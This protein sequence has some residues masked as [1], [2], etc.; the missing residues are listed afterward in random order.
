M[1]DNEGNNIINDE[2]LIEHRR[3]F[4]L[5]MVKDFNERG[6]MN[7]SSRLMSNADVPSIL[8]SGASDHEFPELIQDPIT[9]SEEEASKRIMSYY[10]S[11]PPIRV[12]G[13]VYDIENW[14]QE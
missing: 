13:D 8:A 2:R 9:L 7:I 3:M 14:V 11:N 5:L 12:H 6:D 4:A 1:L 10:G